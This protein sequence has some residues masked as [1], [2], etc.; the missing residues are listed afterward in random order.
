LEVELDETIQAVLAVVDRVKPRRIV[1]DS[2]S[3]MKL[4]ARDPLR[5]RR[6]ILALK[7]LFSGRDDGLRVG[8]D[9]L[10]RRVDR[11]TAVCRSARTAHGQ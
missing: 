4:L 1:F 7:E 8:A 5:Y 2:L 11:R 3:E 10:P 6:Q 9:G